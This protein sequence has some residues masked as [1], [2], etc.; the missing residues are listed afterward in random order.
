M[1]FAMLCYAWYIELS[2]GAMYRVG[3]CEMQRI[4]KHSR[5][6]TGK[7]WQETT[8]MILIS[9]RENNV[10]F[11]SLLALDTSRAM[12]SLIIVP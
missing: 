4:A 2:R 7:A 10:L 12:V 3:V 5:H 11:R 9:F 6:D 8:V 1:L